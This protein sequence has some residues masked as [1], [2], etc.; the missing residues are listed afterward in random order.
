MFNVSN[1]KRKCRWCMSPLLL[2]TPS[3]TS[4]F[5]LKTVI[6]GMKF[7]KY[8]SQVWAFYLDRCR[9]LKHFFTRFGVILA[10]LLQ[11][12]SVSRK[13]TRKTFASKILAQDS[14]FSVWLIIFVTPWTYNVHGTCQP[15]WSQQPLWL[16]I[17]CSYE[18]HVQALSKILTWK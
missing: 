5:H 1:L 8:V 17:I 9:F 16:E 3:F 12:W 15:R 13:I 2:K 7:K 11:L 14:S 6:L 18:G 4:R 10:L